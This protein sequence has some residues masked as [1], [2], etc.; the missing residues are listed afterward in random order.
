MI[1]MSSQS[2]DDTQKPTAVAKLY[3]E[4]GTVLTGISFGSHVSAEGEVRPCCGTAVVH[5]GLAVERSLLL[6]LS[7]VLIED[8]LSSQ[9]VWSDILRA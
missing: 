5:F 3:L 6:S 9:R 4:D 7:L 2:G 1:S 8:R